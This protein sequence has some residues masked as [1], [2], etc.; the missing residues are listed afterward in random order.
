M[1]T[2]IFKR[3]GYDLNEKYGFAQGALIMQSGC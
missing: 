2:Y 1:L 3:A